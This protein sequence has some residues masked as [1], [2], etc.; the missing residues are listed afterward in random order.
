MLKERLGFL[1]KIPFFSKIVISSLIYL[2]LTILYSN[3]TWAELRGKLPLLNRMFYSKFLSFS[4][5]YKKFTEIK[6]EAE[7]Q[8]ES[9]V[10]SVQTLNISE[11]TITP[12]MSFSAVLEP[13][14]RVDVFTKVSGRLEQI[15]VKEGDA[16]KKG[17]KLAK[18]DSMTFELDLAK[19]KASLDS[20]KALYQLSK[21][22]Y[23]IAR[24]NVEIK[25]GEAD[26]RIGLYQ[27]ALAEQSRFAEIVRKK[28]ILWTEKA[29]SDEEIENLRLE[30]SSRELSSSNAKRDLE[31]ILVGIRDEDIVAAG[32]SVPTAKKEKIDL[33]KTINT[34]IEKSEMEV[35]ATNLR[36]SEV[37]LQ[38]TE[39]LIKE[40]VLYSPLDG[41]VAKINKT[42]GELINAGSGGS[43]PVMTVISNDGVYVDFAVNEGDLGKIK[44][45]QNA[46]VSVD[47]IPNRQFKGVVKKISPLVDQKTHTADVK[48]ELLGR[49]S[50][51]KPGMFV[52]AEIQIGENKTAIL[53]PLTSL[54]SVDDKEGS[55]FVMK[56]KKS[57][58]KTIKLGEKKDDRVFVEEGLSAD[59]ILILSP[60]NR[61]YDGLSVMPKFQ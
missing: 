40:A 55:V 20:A 8:T 57:F 51:L 28:E 25:L 39:M 18:L 7:A 11:E 24:R 43:P 53:I 26:K 49:S 34:R 15:Y 6:K 58:K 54:V 33:L 45:G 31:M 2:G 32:Y 37:N 13:I 16:I 29:I 30:L 36:A 19:Q 23:E 42:T 21:D 1:S 12:T 56:D 48:V 52:R 22:K 44:K 46:I 38:S 35:A 60:I 9:G 27:K 59:E 3:L 10:V 41:L 17:Q 5:Q 47:S 4:E 61:L 50:E 14:E